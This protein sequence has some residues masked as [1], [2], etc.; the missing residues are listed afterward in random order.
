MMGPDPEDDLPRALKVKLVTCQTLVQEPLSAFKSAIEQEPPP[1]TIYHYT[2]D[3]GL[4]GILQEGLFRLTDVFSLNDPSELRHGIGIA[5][6]LIR[7]LGQR[8]EVS[9][10]F[11]NSFEIIINYGI[12]E[13]ANFF[14]CCFS[15]NGDELGQWR[16]YGDD[17]RGF[18]LGFDAGMLEQ[19]FAKSGAAAEWGC[20]AFPVTYD[21][22]RLTALLTE[23]IEVVLQQVDA[24]K[25]TDLDPHVASWFYRSL[26]IQLAVGCV[27]ASL[28]FKHP[29]YASECEY[30]FL[31][32]HSADDKLDTLRF[33]RRPYQI[34]RYM[35]FRWG[36]HAAAALQTVTLGP[37]SDYSLGSRLLETLKAFL[38]T[39]KDVRLV[40]S[41]IPYR[42]R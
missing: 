36:A 16:S 30:R 42:G 11:A 7:E 15:K 14:V 34:V 27:D 17:G 20:S 12:A 23:M 10:S 33:R 35:E 37:S 18:A 5:S 2:D 8:S 13:I 19:A 38:P 25:A 21:D 9:K 28:R 26:A 22:A 6:R 31:Q 41:E 3:N 4:V 29:A 1:P 40:R 24:M 32:L 39:K